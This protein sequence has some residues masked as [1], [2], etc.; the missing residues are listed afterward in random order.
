M[1]EAKWG[2]MTHYLADWIARNSG[3]GMNVERWNEMINA[4]NVEGLAEQIRSVGAGYYIITIGQNSGYYLSPNTAYDRFVGINPSKCS[5]RDL[6][7][8]LS[9]AL[10][11][12]GVKLVV[13][14]PSGAPAGDTNARKALGWQNGPNRNCEFQIRWEQVIREWS[15]RWGKKVSGWWFDGC[16]WPNTM[17]RTKDTPNFV[18]LA[19]AARAG[20]PGSVVAFNPG[21]V[22]RTISIT[23]EEDYIAGEIDKP[24]L[25]SAK[26][27]VNGTVDGV[28]IHMLS[29]LGENWGRGLPRFTADQAVSWSKKVADIDGVVTWDVPIQKSGLIA[30]PFIDRLTAVGKAFARP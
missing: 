2:V 25:W 20:N 18:S 17:Y 23:P 27:N 12:W 4:F 15:E 29:F 24:D 3:S 13:Y 26:R 16:Y 5:R 22:Y 1:R 21:V 19:A 8:D 30:R 11:R 7:A 10:R 28:Q 6:V 14:L 9:V